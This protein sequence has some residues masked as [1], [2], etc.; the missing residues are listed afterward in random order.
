MAAMSVLDGYAIVSVVVTV[1]ATLFV[2]SVS[3]TRGPSR[4]MG[5]AYAALSYVAQQAV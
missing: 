5:G 1:L 4:G 3:R 2:K